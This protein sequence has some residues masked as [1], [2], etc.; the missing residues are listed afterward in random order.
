MAGLDVSAQYATRV[1]LQ[2]V[3]ND[4]KIATFG[5]IA[6]FMELIR[7]KL[8]KVTKTIFVY[9]FIANHRL[10][11]QQ[12]KFKFYSVHIGSSFIPLLVVTCVSW[13]FECRVLMYG[14]NVKIADRN[15]GLC[16]II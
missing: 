1:R 12:V 7:K 9:N 4:F 13:F 16:L 8:S 10:R 6:G 15:L 11:L 3:L 5:P 2:H 14:R